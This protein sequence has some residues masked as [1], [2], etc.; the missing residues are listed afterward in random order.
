MTT[1]LPVSSPDPAE[2]AWN[3]MAQL[4]RLADDQSSERD[5]C[6]RLLGRQIRSSLETIHSELL[7]AAIR[8]WSDVHPNIH[9]AQHSLLD[10]LLAHYGPTWFDRRI[11]YQILDE[12]YLPLAEVHALEGLR[13]DALPL[14]R[15]RPIVPVG[16]KLE[17]RCH[18]TNFFGNTA[19]VGLTYPQ[20]SMIVALAHWLHC[21]LG[22][23]DPQ[24]PY[25]SVTLQQLMD[26]NRRVVGREWDFGSYKMRFHQNGSLKLTFQAPGLAQHVAD[27]LNDDPELPPIVWRFPPLDPSI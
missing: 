24:L 17:L 26:A 21:I 8:E 15:R 18:L 27:R 3:A 10:G 7:T 4:I 6:L 19:P 14:C 12:A 16:A 2:I 25:R 9:V 5:F 20:D 22:Q 1:P 11:I 23:G 13:K